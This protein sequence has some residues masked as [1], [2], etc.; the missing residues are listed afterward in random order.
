MFCVIQNDFLKIRFIYNKTLNVGS[1]L[2]GSGVVAEDSD[3]W[4]NF[5]FVDGRYHL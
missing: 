4:T 1:K 5:S 3:S 2:S